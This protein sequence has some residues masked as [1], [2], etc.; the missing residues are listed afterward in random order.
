VCVVN[1]TKFGASGQAGPSI[2]KTR[3]TIC[4]M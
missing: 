4:V 3:D 1:R 2:N